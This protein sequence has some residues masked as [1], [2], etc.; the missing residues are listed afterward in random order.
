MSARLETLRR[1][2]S[3]TAGDEQVDGLLVSS[4]DNRRYL[5]GFTGSAGFLIITGQEA[6]LLTDFR[7]VEQATAQAPHFTVAKIEATAWPALAAELKRLR[8]RR[9]GFESENLTVDSHRRLLEALRESGAEVELV[10]RR[11]FVEEQR[12]AKDAREVELIRRAVELADRAFETVA[13]RLR[14][15]VTEREVAWRLEVYMRERGASE[16]SFPI[17]VA[18][19]P[20][21]AMPHHRPTDRPIE[22]GEPIVIDMGCRLNGYC[23]DMT[24]TITLGEPDAQFWRIYD[25][26]LRA[27]QACEDGLKAGILGR[28][29]DGLARDVI[30]AAGYVDQFGHGTGHGVGL[31]VHEHPWLSHTRGDMPLREGAVVTVEPGIYLPGWGGIRIEDMVVVGPA[32]GLILTTAH[33]QPVV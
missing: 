3:A 32:R 17:I 33:K 30:K 22:R 2:L 15:G 13:A 9:I 20:N 8:H 14:P 19:G 21:G 26:V 11:G 24:R 23:S 18:A 5:S 4:A 10:P 27:Q 16:V 31:A 25:I 1:R 28:D 7:Y 29:A 12:Q 6:I